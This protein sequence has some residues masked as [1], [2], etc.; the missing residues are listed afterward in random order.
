MPNHKSCDKRLRQEAKRSARN[1]YVKMTI[2]TLE[3]KMRSDMPKEEKQNLLDEVYSKLDRAAKRR[4]IH[5][6]T[7]A[8]RKSRIATYFNKELAEAK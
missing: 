5:P 3:K 7:A 6:R 1:H 8:R 4:V 2:K